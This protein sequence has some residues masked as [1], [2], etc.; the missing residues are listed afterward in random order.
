MA[1]RKKKGLFKG[2]LGNLINI[3]FLEPDEPR[4]DAEPKR[5]ET[6]GE[7]WARRTAEG[8][9]DRFYPNASP[10][11]RRRA[12]KR[13]LEKLRP[14]IEEWERETWEGIKKFTEKAK[15]VEAEE[16]IQR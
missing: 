6:A 9:V 5:I 13:M 14:H 2:P 3:K 15:E 8:W 12:K 16:Y 1:R 7:K 4:S 10:A 11:K